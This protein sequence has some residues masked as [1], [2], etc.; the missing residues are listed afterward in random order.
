[1][2]W[3]IIPGTRQR[4]PHDRRWTGILQQLLGDDIRVIEECLNGRTTVWNDPFRPGRNGKDLL[5]PILH[6]HA[7]IDLVIIFVGTNDLQAIYG[8][9]AYESSLGAGVLV[10]IVQGCRAEPML[11][12]PQVLLLAPPR[13]GKLGGTMVEKFHGA[14]EKSSHFTRCY[15]RIA[16][17]RGCSFIDAAEF[18]QPS[19]VDGVHLD[20]LQHRQLA[21]ALHHRVLA[22]LDR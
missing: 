7:P 16:E 6:S 17:E 2:S 22:I 19:D 9:G 4:H 20:E 15:A 10:D 3:G 5:L 12:A 1:M 14:E 11:V 13:I 21:A 18:I 8:V